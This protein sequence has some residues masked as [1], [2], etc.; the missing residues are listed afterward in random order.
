MLGI[1]STKHEVRLLPAG[2]KDLVGKGNGSSATEC[3]GVEGV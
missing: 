2:R 3:E 1:M